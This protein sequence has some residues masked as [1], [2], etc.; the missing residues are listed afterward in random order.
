MSRENSF[1]P[2]PIQVAGSAS[3]KLASAMF[4][5][6]ATNSNIGLLVATGNREGGFYI[7]PDVSPPS[8]MFNSI[9]NSSTIEF[10]TDR[11][12]IVQD[13]N[14][15]HNLVILFKLTK[16]NG[17]NFGNLREV[18]CYLV[19]PDGATPYNESLFSYCQ[20]MP[21]IHDT[22][23]M[24]GILRHSPG[25]IVRLKFIVVQNEH[26]D[27]SPTQ[28]TIFRMNWDMTAIQNDQQ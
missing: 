27:A 12:A 14:V 26:S 23:V 1:L 24:R 15:L 16:P 3:V 11:A 5:R 20:P 13:S 21:G 25:D 28:L 9:T 17:S 6:E 10:G 2:V 4:Y 7:S 19:H 18:R 22:M 8:N